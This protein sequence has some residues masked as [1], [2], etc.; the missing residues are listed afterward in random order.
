MRGLGEKSIYG[1]RRYLNSCDRHLISGHGSQLVGKRGPDQQTARTG[2]YS[3][4][5]SQTGPKPVPEPQVAV[6][7]VSRIH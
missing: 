6:T 5:E 1:I 2:Y 3:V 4:R 7:R